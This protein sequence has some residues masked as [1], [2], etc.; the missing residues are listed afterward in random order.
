MKRNNRAG[1]WVAGAVVLVAVIIG[2]VGLLWP[3]PG[4]TP[5]VA[6]DDSSQSTAPVGEGPCPKSLSA[7]TTSTVPADLRWAA[8]QGVTWPVS[9]TVGPT[10]TTDGFATCFQQSPIGAALFSTGFIGSSTDHPAR[11]HFNYYMVPSPAK[12]EVLGAIDKA[13]TVPPSLAQQF[14]SIGANYVGYRIDQFGGTTAEVTVVMS[15]PN[16]ATGYR[17][18]RLSLVWQNGDWRVQAIENGGDTNV[19]FDVL[20]GQ[21]T[22]WSA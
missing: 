21:F 18:I 1:L 8:S 19:F 16:T 6:T 9:D 10:S 3:R 13:S 2:V 20:D 15:I 12:D 22:K 5:P 17:G 7:S 14:K 11:E 4:E